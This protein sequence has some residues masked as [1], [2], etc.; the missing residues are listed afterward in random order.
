M[1]CSNH[2]DFP[3]GIFFFFTSS[4]YLLSN[5]LLS[6][7]NRYSKI[8]DVFA[9]YYGNLYTSECST[10][11]QELNLPRL[12]DNWGSTLDNSLTAEEIRI[13][14]AMNQAMNQ[15]HAGNPMARWVH[16]GIFQ[17]DEWTF[18]TTFE[19]VQRGPLTRSA[20]T[21]TDASFNMSNPQKRQRPP[22][23]WVV[24]PN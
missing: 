8:N 18:P 16:G 14:E 10:G 1:G 17:E 23:L 9:E 19:Y 21:N 6:V 11:P 7:S 22:S 13:N 24:S 20:A 2:G 15:L 5:W 3:T 4:Y 12:D